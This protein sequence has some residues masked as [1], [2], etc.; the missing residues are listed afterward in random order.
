MVHQSHF[1][2]ICRDW[3]LHFA[4]P[5]TFGVRPR[6]AAHGSVADPTHPGSTDLAA[7]VVVRG[8]GDAGH[9]SLL[10][11]GLARWDE[12]MDVEHLERLQDLLG[13]LANRGEDTSRTR[14]ACYSGAGFSPALRAVEAQGQVVLVDL[15]RLYGR[16]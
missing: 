4:D 8:H 15:D 3:A 6:S 2:Q 13:I 5:D 11:V 16:R 9:G 10:S 12:V 7:E 1:A 14:P